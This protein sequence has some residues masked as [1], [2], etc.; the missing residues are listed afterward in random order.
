MNKKYQAACFSVFLLL[1]FL[2]EC[3][4]IQKKADISGIKDIAEGMLKNF[5][6][7]DPQEIRN[8]IKHFSLEKQT[9]PVYLNQVKI[10]P[11]GKWKIKHPP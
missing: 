2:S 4:Y 11:L 6:P 9:S 8:F 1:L 3:T 7:G 5:D 10:S